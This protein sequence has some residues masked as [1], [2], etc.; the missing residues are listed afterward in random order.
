MT[1]MRSLTALL[2]LSSVAALPGCSM[3]GDHNNRQQEAS[4]TLPQPPGVSVDTI[5]QAQA[6]LKQEGEYNGNIDGVWGPST[7]MA[8][9]SYQ[10]HH[11]LPETAQLDS[12]T[13]N[14]LNLSGQNQG[15]G[16]PQAGAMPQGSNIQ[17]AASGSPDQ[18]SARRGV[19]G[20]TVR[21]AQT[22]LKQSGDYHGTVDGRWGPAT[23]A[24]VRSYQQKHNLPVTGRLDRETM[25]SMNLSGQQRA[26][27]SPSA[28]ASPPSDAN[29]P[30]AGGSPDAAAPQGAPKSN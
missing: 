29:P 18:M 13:V 2:L 14:S 3:F 22:Q 15:A 20:T 21:Q 8:V 4:Y 11:N 12:Q 10:Q 24:A 25:D 1:G 17:G 27:P 23:Q 7:Q 30:A 16:S 5:K 6:Q 9:R 26:A 28:P 19:S